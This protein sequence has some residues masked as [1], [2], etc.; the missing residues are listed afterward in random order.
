MS[1]EEDDERT[2]ALGGMLMVVK[3]SCLHAVQMLDECPPLETLMA[4]TPC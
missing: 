1:V 3:L 2:G 4:T